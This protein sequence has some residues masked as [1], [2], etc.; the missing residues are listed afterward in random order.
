MKR[1]TS[2]F[3]L[4]LFI[5]TLSIGASLAHAQPYPNRPIQLVIAGAPG[6]GID[7]AARAAAD[8]LGKILK[9]PVIPLNKPGG[10]G[11]VAADFAAKS[12]KDGYTLHYG[13][14]QGLIIGPALRPKETP[15]DPIHDFEPLGMHVFFPIVISVQADAPWKKFS[16]VIDYAKKNPGSFRCGTVGGIHLQLETIKFATGVDIAQLP[17]KGGS[18]AITALLGGHIESTFLAVSISHPHY[19]SGKLRGVLLDTSVPSLP[20][21]PT[22]AQLGYKQ[23]LHPSWFGFLA[24]AGIP[25]EAK[26]ILIP[27]VEKTVKNPELSAKLQKLW[28]VPNYLSPSE[29][30][31]LHRT[32][33]EDA[34][35]QFKRLGAR[36]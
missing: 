12:P 35:V 25:E 22:W 2:F 10:A 32:N 5:M 20:N 27:A 24:P 23:N 30:Q 1:L 6:D 4:V 15:F 26:K 3:V 14:S 28:F 36:Q 31:R 16:D 21:I 34:M 8:E 18:Q 17:F 19:E 9:V 7:I 11:T 13:S 29:F 33:Y